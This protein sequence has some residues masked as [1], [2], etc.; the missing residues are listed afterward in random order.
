MKSRSTLLALILITPFIWSCGSKEVSYEGKKA[1]FLLGE[2]EYGTPETLPAFAKT[3]LEPLGIESSF[4]FA[5]GN[6]R[7]SPL[8]H[9]FEGIAALE[10]AD[11]LIL[12]TRRRFPKE[13]DLAIIRDWIESGKPMIGIRTASH[14]F[15]ER[16]KGTGYQAPEGH[17]S[18]NTIDV[19]VL[20]ASYQGHYDEKD[21]GPLQVTTWL[22]ESV[23]KHPI[24]KRLD[25]RE[26]FSIGNKLYEYIEPDPAIEVLLSARWEE[27]EPP[28]P[29]AW[30]NEKGGKRV[31][32]MSPGS[33]DEM[34]LPQVKS[35]LQAAVLWGLDGTN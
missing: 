25:F 30:T 3:H 10:A 31:F 24:V 17:A 5:E 32:Y 21:G 33:Q 23:S 26:P 34:A 8:C 7:E 28:H 22:E 4:V 9:T 6:D 20:G 11:I 16:A 13:E 18:W 12:S 14:A 29:V 27:G 35:L 2:H 19:D 15:G 1:F